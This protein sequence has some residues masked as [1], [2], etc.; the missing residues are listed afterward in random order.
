MT[1]IEASTWSWILAGVALIVAVLLL[2]PTMALM[3]MGAGF[4]YG[5]LFVPLLT[6]AI[7]GLAMVLAVALIVGQSVLERRPG[8]I[9]RSSGVLIGCFFLCYLVIAGV[10]SYVWG[11]L[12]SV[13][14]VH[15]GGLFSS[16]RSLQWAF[17]MTR[18]MP[19]AVSFWLALRLTL[20]LCRLPT[21]AMPP[22]LD[23][24]HRRHASTIF[25]V[26]FLAC[27]I[28]VMEVV[29]QWQFELSG[30]G[31]IPGAATVLALLFTLAA[32]LGAWLGLK[33]QRGERIRPGL[34]LLAALGTWLA[35]A[36]LL[37]GMA[38]IA[39]LVIFGSGDGSTALMVSGG[40]LALV[41]L[42]SS[43]F[44]LAWGF[45]RLIWRRVP[46]GLPS[47]SAAVEK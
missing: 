13:A 41:L 20:L 1:R 47:P 21:N 31:W 5:T 36:L 7:I 4:S 30:D 17:A 23:V 38:V 26:I 6:N 29:I 2:I 34:L 35:S 16:M 25:A 10:I 28:T 12:M 15:V 8:L 33:Y 22:S 40:L 45:T 3:H 14:I 18:W 46:S 44:F 39:L 43:P 37:A 32:W 9:V 42:L 19:I 24:P 27:C 11:Q